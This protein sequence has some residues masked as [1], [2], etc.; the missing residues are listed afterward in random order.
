MPETDAHDLRQ[1]LARHPRA[2][3]GFYPTPLEPLPRLGAE[4]GLPRLAMKREDMSGLALGGNK[5]RLLEYI[6]GEA[7]AQG[8][9]TLVAGGGKSQSN[10]GRLCAAAARA[11]GLQPVILLSE[12]PT[13]TPEMQGNLLVQYLLGSD[14]RVVSADAIRHDVHP[15]F[16][17]HHLMVAKAEALRAT[18]RRPYV[19][20]TSSVPLAALGFVDCAIELAE[21]L[22]AAAG[23]PTQVYLTST[24][25]TQ[26]GLLLAAAALGLPW[27]V[28]GVACSPALR[29]GEN[30]ARIANGAAE[31]L[32]L[33]AR[34]DPGEVRTVDYAG[35][36]YGVIDEPTRE[37]L[38]LTAQLEAVILDPVYTGKGMAGLIGEARAGR[39]PSAGPVVF[40]HTGGAATNFAY[41]ADLVGDFSYFAATDADATPQGPRVPAGAIA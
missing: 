36:G 38:R 35:P 22:G 23:E 4:V 3:L 1:R 15:R 29:A 33:S 20:P 21:Q 10:H 8:A 40:V 39:V 17:L 31:L 30:V 27:T 14:T 26:A 13:V 7:L 9:D 25:S 6:L 18:G 16:G 37:A 11:V 2:S 19:L 41:A 32:G 34:F 5:V 28:T 24:G 12:D